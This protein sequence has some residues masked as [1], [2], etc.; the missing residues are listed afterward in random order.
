MTTVKK[1]DGNIGFGGKP[2]PPEGEQKY[3]FNGFA[4]LR[5]KTKEMLIIQAEYAIDPDGTAPIECLCWLANE[6]GLESLM[7]I[8]I[9]SG[10]HKKLMAKDKSLPDPVVEGWDDEQVLLKPE[11]IEQLGIELVG[12]SAF[13]TIEH[14]DDEWKDEEKGTIQKRRKSR[15]VSIRAFDGKEGKP[16]EGTPPTETPGE[17]E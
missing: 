2:L 3:V 4:E 10:V 1:G 12:C 11:F 6:K 17:W 14:F 16:A 7:S 8:I 13:I 9:E 15:V 5:G